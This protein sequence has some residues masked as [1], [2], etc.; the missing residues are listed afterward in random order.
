[1]KKILFLT[2]SIV[3]FGLFSQAPQLINYQGVA[4]NSS[5]TVLA[6]T[7]I[8]LTVSITG[9]SYVYTETHSTSSNAVGIFT[10]HIGG[11]A[12]Q[13]SNTFAGINW[14]SANQFI[15]TVIDA[16]S[17]PQPLGSQQLVSVPYALYAQNA[18]SSSASSY[19][20][21]TN[22]SITSGSVINNTAPNVTLTPSGPITIAG[23]Y[24]SF[25]IGATTGTSSAGPPPNFV[26]NS[27]NT[28]SSNTTTNTH[29]I[30]IVP[31]T[32]TFSAGVLTLQPGGDTTLIPSSSPW[33]RAGTSVYLN[34]N[35]DNVG[36]GIS[37]PS[38]K[39]QIV[40]TSA[41]ANDV[42][43]GSTTTGDAL[44]VVKFA[45]AGNVASFSLTPSNTGNGLSIGNSGSGIGINVNNA[46]NNA[47]SAVSTGGSPTI[48]GNNTFSGASVQGAKSLAAGVTGD[49]VQGINSNTVGAAVRAT[50]GSSPNSALALWI[51]NGHIKSTSTGSVSPTVSIATNSLIG[52]SPTATITSTSTDVKGTVTVN[53][54]TFTGA[55]AG[56]Y[57]DVNVAFVK[58]YSLGTTVLLTGV[59]PGQFDYRV[60][61][62]TN[63]SFVVRIVNNTP[64][65]QS[66]APGF[67]YFRFNYFV[68]E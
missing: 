43:I 25:T 12:Q 52:F 34:N 1:M 55:A 20:A 39:L 60:I 29:T 33:D 32:A 8:Q 26:I 64:A 51:D 59:E 41:T 7:A 5:G 38:S 30:N 13:G 2:L 48:I 56:S 62:Q 21:G 28:V 46:S 16:G 49:A 14:G 44:Q 11:G 31:P 58:N 35:S 65:G 37:S 68:I 47:I 4:R 3:S 19:V 53:V 36:I 18:G 10:I 23:S 40:S 66:F 6:N 22:I 9:G 54:P 50:S 63:T 57:V 42:S 24:P 15:N 27:P 67:P 61:S 45:T 17:G